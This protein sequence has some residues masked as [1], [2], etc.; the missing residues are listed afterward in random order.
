MDHPEA[1]SVSLH[2]LEQEWM[3]SAKRK[4]LSQE[5]FI[6][7]LIADWAIKIWQMIFIIGVI[8]WTLVREWPW[9]HTVFF[10]LHGIV[11]LMKQH[12]YGF[13]NGH[14]NTAHRRRRYLLARLKE[15]E[16]VDPEH[17]TSPTVPLV[18]EISTAHLDASPSADRRRSTANQSS[19]E[20]SDIDRISKAIAA[21]S[22]LSDA[23]IHLFERL[24]KWEIDALADELQGT[25]SSALMAY[26]SNLTFGNHYKWIPLP[27][28]V[29]QIEYPR[30]DS[31]DWS[32]VAE[33]FVAMIG[34]IFVMIQVSQHSICKL[35]S[36]FCREH[37]YNSS[38]MTDPIVMKTVAMKENKV[39][40]ARRFA[41]FPWLLSDLMFPFMVEYL[42]SNAEKLKVKV[43][44]VVY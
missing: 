23:Q 20:D 29:Y 41:E 36:T 31:I 25:A 35:P 19:S 12:A 34:V 17:G 2:E 11:M 33:K 15:L 40:L 28:L 10:V 30:T 42:V 43:L 3:D 14:L 4:A 24:L 27:T 26:P 13:Y 6:H 16:D 21:K 38:P 1:C 18:T 44:S 5:Y 39:P 37:T 8:S 7:K 9:T 32:Y 22:P